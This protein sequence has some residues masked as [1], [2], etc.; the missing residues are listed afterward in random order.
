MASPWSFVRAPETT[1]SD[2]FQTHDLD[3]AEAAMSSTYAESEIRPSVRNR[4][5]LKLWLSRSGGMNLAY[6]NFE[7]DVRI[8][9]PPLSSYYIVATPS[10]GHLRVGYGR[11][12][13][14]VT[15]GHGVVLGPTESLVFEEWSSD[16]KIFGARINRDDLESDLAAMLGRPIAGPIKFKFLIDLQAGEARSFLRAID[17]MYDEARQPDGMSKN[18]ALSARMSQL[19]RTALLVCHPHNFSEELTAPA[20]QVLPRTIQHAVELIEAEPDRVV[21]VADVAAAA[22]LSV[23]AVEDGFKR[24]LGLSPMTY[25]RHTRLAR[26]HSDLIEASPDSATVSQVASRWGFGHLG[27]FTE[28]YRK[29]YGRLPSQTLRAGRGG[30]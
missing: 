26:A 16:C 12:S 24:H 8:T 14:V 25:V 23:R 19:A 17:L 28:A 9:A 4:L 7:T 20:G 3:R 27:R 22:G 29:R 1:D 10:A 6:T 18:P 15:P 30:P 21:T 2:F 13:V 11:E 5:N